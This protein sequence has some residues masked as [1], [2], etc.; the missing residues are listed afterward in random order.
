M[1]F[2]RHGASAHDIHDIQPLR[3]P[4]PEPRAGQIEGGDQAIVASADHDGVARAFQ[5]ARCLQWPSAMPSFR[6]SD[7]PHQTR[8]VASHITA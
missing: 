8:F 7:A 4:N 1:E 5:R 3:H 2:L 6:I